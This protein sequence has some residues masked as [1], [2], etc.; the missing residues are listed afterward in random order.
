MSQ[1]IDTDIES[2]VGGGMGRSPK[3]IVDT[4]KYI[5]ARDLHIT[6]RE[7]K[8]MPLCDVISL[9]KLWN[10]Q[11]KKEEKDMKKLNSKARRRR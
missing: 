7:L 11:R 5:F 6:P 4:L 1:L 9:F 3:Q 8:K 2:L 10:K